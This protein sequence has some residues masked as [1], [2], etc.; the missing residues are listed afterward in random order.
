MNATS[1][2]AGQDARVAHGHEDVVAVLPLELHERPV[3]APHGDHE[4]G[5]AVDRAR[6]E[7]SQERHRLERVDVLDADAAVRARDEVGSD[8]V[9]GPAAAATPQRIAVP[10][11]APQPAS[12]RALRR[13][14]AVSPARIARM[15]RSPAVGQLAPLGAAQVGVAERRAAQG[16]EPH[17][18]AGGVAPCGVAGQHVVARRREPRAA[19][20]EQSRRGGG[21]VASQCREPGRELVGRGGAGGHD[22]AERRAPTGGESGAAW[23]VHVAEHGLDVDAQPRPDPEHCGID[24]H[25][26]AGDERRACQVRDADGQRPARGAAVGQEQP[27]VVAQADIAAGVQRDIDGAGPSAAQS[28]PRARP[29]P[30]RARVS[31]HRA[32]RPARRWRRGT[33]PPAGAPRRRRSGRS[34]RG[35]GGRRW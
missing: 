16:R 29:R 25:R 12:A 26:F 11:L 7:V 18:G 5:A 3:V 30:Q 10:E 34:R 24:P 13:A 31:H 32:R 8:L 17:R 1:C 27:P 23:S 9:H 28:S 20:G 4:L 6:A 22:A 15:T 21:V 14:A 2:R 35:R 33:A 19:A